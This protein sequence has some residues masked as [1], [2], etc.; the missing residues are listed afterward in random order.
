MMNLPE[1]AAKKGTQYAMDAGFITDSDTQIA[2]F[3]AFVKKDDILFDQDENLIKQENK[4]ASA[5]VG[6]KGDAIRVG[7]MDDVETG[8]NWAKLYDTKKD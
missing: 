8:G 5:V 3:E 2:V 1:G 6:V 4:V 7:S